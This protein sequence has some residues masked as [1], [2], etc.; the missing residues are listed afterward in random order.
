MIFRSLLGTGAIVWAA[1]LLTLPALA[2]T[3][4]KATKPVAAKSAP[5]KSAPAKPGAAKASAKSAPAAQTTYKLPTGGKPVAVPPPPASLTTPA[6]QKPAAQAATASAPKPAAKAAAPAKPKAKKAAKKASKKKKQIASG[7]GKKVKHGRAALSPMEKIDK[8]QLA[9]DHL[10]G[11]ENKSTLDLLVS[12]KETLRQGDLETAGVLLRLIA[13]ETPS[14]DVATVVNDLI[15][16]PLDTT[17]T[18]VLIQIARADRADAVAGDTAK[19]SVDEKVA[20]PLGERIHAAHAAVQAAPRTPR[21]EALA[22]YK[23][24]VTEG[25]AE[26]AAVALSGVVQG[27]LDEAV[28]N[29]ANALLEVENIIPPGAQAA[30]N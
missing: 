15:G 9:T 22:A 6:P 25:N 10:S 2:A 27:P 21:I 29:T 24:A 7:K 8:G 20:S 11:A 14:H 1:S 30:V 3:P 28:V 18:D 26:A 4:P 23:H 5:A 13:N 17:D 19:K 12:Y 16:M